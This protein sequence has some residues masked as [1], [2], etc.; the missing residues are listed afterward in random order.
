MLTVSA[1][2][3]GSLDIYTLVCDFSFPSRNTVS[4]GPLSPKQPTNQPISFL[5]MIFIS[6]CTPLLQLYS[7]QLDISETSRSNRLMAVILE[8]FFAL[9]PGRRILNKTMLP[10]VDCQTITKYSA[11]FSQILTNISLNLCNN[12]DQTLF[13]NTLTFARSLG[14]G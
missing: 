1:G 11:I 3:G 2:V 14:R 13:S 8:L 6:F 12:S 7:N 9:R 4:K 10:H 5:L